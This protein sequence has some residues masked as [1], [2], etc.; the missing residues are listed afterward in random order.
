MAREIIHYRKL[1]PLR[2]LAAKESG[3][4]N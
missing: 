2:V 1:V 4:L 3:R